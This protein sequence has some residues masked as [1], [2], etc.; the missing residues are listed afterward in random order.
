MSPTEGKPGAGIRG[1][2]AMDH[3]ADI[4]FRAWAPSLDDLF[5]V[6][7]EA[8]MSLGVA[9]A[10]VE[11]VSQRTVRVE[12]LDAEELLVAWLQELL[13]LWTAEGF[14]ACRFR[15][16]TASPGA[17][18]T[19]GAWR[20]EGS[21][22]G[23]RWDPGKHEAYTDIKAVTYHDLRIRRERSPE[24]GSVYRVDVVLDI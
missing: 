9:L 8:V 13:Y 22:E 11:P 17:Q 6:A 10:G 14:V 5:A 15:V 24:G 2:E 4:G 23:E 21:I 19:K 3:T 1:W 20:L 12:G 16:K 7:A 18:G